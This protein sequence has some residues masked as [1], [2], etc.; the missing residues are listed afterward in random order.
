MRYG[1]DDATNFSVEVHKTLALEA[2][3]ASTYLAKEREPSLFMMPNGKRI[4]RSF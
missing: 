2:Y 1:S 3:K 4:I